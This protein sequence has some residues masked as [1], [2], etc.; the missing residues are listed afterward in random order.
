MLTGPW[1][2]LDGVSFWKDVVLTGAST[3]AVAATATRRMPFLMFFGLSEVLPTLCKVNP[4]RSSCPTLGSLSKECN[5]SRFH[6]NQRNPN[7]ERNLAKALGLG[8]CLVS[9]ADLMGI[10]SAGLEKV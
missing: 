7:V 2:Q 4:V 6:I 9:C 1:D 8:R 10:A 3:N 5:R